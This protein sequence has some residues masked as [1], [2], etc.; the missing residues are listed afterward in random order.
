MPC[1]VLPIPG[2]PSASSLRPTLTQSRKGKGNMSQ[3]VALIRLG[4]PGTAETLAALWI[5]CHQQSS[6][7]GASWMPPALGELPLSSKRTRTTRAGCCSGEQSG[8]AQAG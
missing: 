5:S 2:H 7:C 6:G 1:L 8:A 3:P 4:P